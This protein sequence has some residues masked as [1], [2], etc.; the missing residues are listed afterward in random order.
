MLL[1]YEL[2][3]FFY[4]LHLQV[5]Q[6]KMAEYRPTKAHVLTRA[7]GS[8]GTYDRLEKLYVFLSLAKDCH[9]GN[10]PAVL[11]I[12]IVGSLLTVSGTGIIPSCENHFIKP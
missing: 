2:M 6:T 4:L 9:L 11:L 10:Q 7:I 12:R 8:C 1:I 3:L 5:F